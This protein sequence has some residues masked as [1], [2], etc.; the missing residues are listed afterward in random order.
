MPDTFV[1]ADRFL[2]VQTPL[3][4]DT[5][6]LESLN[7]YEEL[8]RLYEFE[9]EMLSLE[10]SIPA[11]QVVGQRITATITS[12]GTPRHFDGFVHRFSARG[13]DE[14]GFRRYHASI[15]PWL[16][17]LTKR[18]DCRI[19]QAK[20]IPEILEEVFAAAGF[21]DYDTG[22]ITGDHPA[23]EYC[24]QY[25]ESD[26]NFV[27]RL[28]EE[29][30]IFY[31]FR[32]Q[33]GQHTL[34][35]ADATSA[36]DDAPDKEVPYSAGERIPRQI[37]RWD[38]RYE[39]ITGRFALTDYNFKT[40]KNS[41]LGTTSTLVDL[42]GATSHEIFDYPGGH[43]D[44]G[45]G[46]ARSKLRM[47]EEEAAF[48]L[49]EGDSECTTFVPGARFSV[50]EHVI[51]D[52]VGKTY[53]LHSIRHA[54]VDTSTTLGPNET[55]SYTNTFL[56]FP[57]ATVFR[58]PLVTERPVV[59]GLESAVVTGP[60]GEEIYTDEHGR[61][62]VHFHWDR[63]GKKDETSSCWIR[64]AQT[65]AGKNWGAIYLPR[66]GHEVVVDF[67]NGDP[68]LPLVTGCVY[69]ADNPP[70]YD[71]PANRT[72]SGV[73]TR[74]SLG[75]G[76]PNYNEIRFEDKKGEELVTFHA[77]KDES[78]TVENDKTESVGH[79]ETIDIGN[80]R[81]E[82]VGHDET[83]SVGNDRTRT[84]AANESVS[85]GKDKTKS[86]ADNESVSVGKNRT[87]S[88][89]DNETRSVGKDRTIS[90]G[91]NE[92][93]TVGKDQTVQV[94]DNRSSQIGKND[95]LDVGK[96]FALT[97]ADQIVFKTGQA[98]IVMKKS[99][100]ISIKGKD[101][102]VTGSGKILIKASSTVTI[103]G[104]KVMTN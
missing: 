92:S 102:S 73:K 1:Q 89:G 68:D 28:M 95:T 84:V 41:L 90:V 101:V 83:M 65:W 26:F 98:S 18:S 39:Y 32:H 91:K 62:K 58:P 16:W 30:G 38:H 97:A 61:I 67:L 23:H 6:L 4:A 86:V 76:P 47:E 88:V 87:D 79:D 94:A 55:Q 75:G 69:N 74:S 45:L 96:V 66:I 56:C 25:R 82:S 48:E 81:T 12:E 59:N 64:V 77:E 72:Q 80:D 60:A 17:F 93:R 3:G 9:L 34:M 8:S 20:T 52:E 44:K 5:L 11:N 53:V 27:S 37:S 19:F 71:L 85:V 49:I 63:A 10:P 99:G 14:R 42:P 104:S 57:A 33:E 21:A 40:P 78:S 43:P 2:H 35:L 7:G 22:G 46:T 24:V 13:T 31:F 50:S 70:P 51:D 100:E 103:K 54:A 29:E 36:Y 15:V